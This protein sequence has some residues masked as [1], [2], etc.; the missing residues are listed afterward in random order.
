MDV[1]P[2]LYDEIVHK[3]EGI[4]Q[5]DAANTL[6]DIVLKDKTCSSVK[7]EDCEVILAYLHSLKL[8][9]LNSIL[10][11][12]KDTSETSEFFYTIMKHDPNKELMIKIRVIAQKATSWA[13]VKSDSVS[14]TEYNIK[15]KGK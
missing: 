10:R 5:V 8:E 6:K 7:A 12:W 4:A 11:S 1:G 3:M 14:K 2:L 13:I 9:T 15:N